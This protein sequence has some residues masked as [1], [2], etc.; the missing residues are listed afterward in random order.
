MNPESEIYRK[1]KLAAMK[2]TKTQIQKIGRSLNQ[3]LASN[4]MNYD[5]IE[6]TIT[7]LQK[8]LGEMKGSK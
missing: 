1:A 4:N 2:Q 7:D 3:Q 6:R 5:K 8:M